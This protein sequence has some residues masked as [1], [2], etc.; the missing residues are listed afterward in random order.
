MCLMTALLLLKSDSARQLTL[1]YLTAKNHVIRGFC[2]IVAAR[3]WPA[4]LLKSGRGVF[5]EDEYTNLAAVIA[6]YRPEHGAAAAGAAPAGK[7][8]AAQSRVAASG[9][10]VVLFDGAMLN[11]F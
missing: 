2:G 4:D 10:G 11:L 6:V 3:R 8:A 9:L 7:M 1:Q 5:S